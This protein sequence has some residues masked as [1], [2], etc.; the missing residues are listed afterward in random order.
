MTRKIKESKT[1]IV[2]IYS[3]TAVYVPGQIGV[4]PVDMLVDTRL[5]VTLVCFRV[6]ENEKRDF[7]LGLVSNAVMSANGQ[8]LDIRGKCELK[9]SLGGVTAVHPVLV[10]ADVTQDCLLLLALD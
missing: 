2:S 8:P 6:L 7:K 5:A 3:G 9:I 4:Q 1:S 10:A